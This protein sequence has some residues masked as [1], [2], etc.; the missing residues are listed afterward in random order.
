M[1]ISIQTE[2]DM[3]KLTSATCFVCVC[4]G[5]EDD[6]I[7]IYSAKRDCSFSS[8][9]SR[10]PIGARLGFF[11]SLAGKHRPLAVKRN[12]GTNLLRFSDHRWSVS[13]Q[14]QQHFAHQSSLP[15]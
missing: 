3:N 2:I 4:G 9:L 10:Q 12:A 5:E 1:T 14:Q 11:S 15:Y 13:E 7:D 6:L 8:S